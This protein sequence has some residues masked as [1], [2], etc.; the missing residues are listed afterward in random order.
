MTLILLCLQQIKD[1]KCANSL[2]SK[3]FE[4]MSEPKKVIVCEFGFGGIMHIPPMNVKSKTIGT[5]LGLNASDLFPDKVCY[6]NLSKE[7]K[8]IFKRFQGN[9]LKKLTDDMMSIGVENEQDRLM[10]KRIFIPYIQMALL[11]PISNWN[12]E[13]LVAR[14]RAE[15][16]GH[17]VS[18]QNTFSNLGVFYGIVKMAETKKKLKEMRKKEKK[19]EKKKPSSS[20]ESDSS[21]I[22]VDFFSEFESEEDSEEPRRKQ[23]KR[24]AKKLESRKRKQ[25]LEESSSKSKS[26]SNNE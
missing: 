5:A 10:F 19:E 2:L 18:K 9:I 4:K 23:P 26:E 6:K 21:E 17:M 12:R 22:D 1:L 15:I 20:S 14:I 3:K 16:D 25:I 11:L 7:N 24:A 13:Q 8:L